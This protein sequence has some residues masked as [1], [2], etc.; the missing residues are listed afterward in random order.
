VDDLAYLEE[1]LAATP[2]YRKFV[3]EKQYEAWTGQWQPANIRDAVYVKI[4]DD[5]VGLVLLTPSLRPEGPVFR[6]SC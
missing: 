5:V 1:L 4:D 3:A 2:Q 6:G